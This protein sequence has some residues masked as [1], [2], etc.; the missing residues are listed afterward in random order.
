MVKIVISD[1]GV[2]FRVSRIPRSRLGLRLSI[3]QRVETIGGRVFIDSKPGSGTNI[4]L[5]VDLP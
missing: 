5:E 3:I 1:D 4:V 2:G